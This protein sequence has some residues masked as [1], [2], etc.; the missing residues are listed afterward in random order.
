MEDFILGEL[1]LHS[2]LFKKLDLSQKKKK[3]INETLSLTPMI[4]IILR[5]F[6]GGIFEILQS[7]YIKGSSGRH[8]DA[9]YFYISCKAC[10]GNPQAVERL[11]SEKKIN[12]FHDY[13]DSTCSFHKDV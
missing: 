5:I 4:I 10:F 1:G 13:W 9:V 2:Q 8:Y 11:Q 12:A 3:K 6:D 7:Y